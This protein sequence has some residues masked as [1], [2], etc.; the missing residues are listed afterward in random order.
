VPVRPAGGDQALN[1]GPFDLASSSA[2][3]R[4]TRRTAPL[5]WAGAVCLIVVVAAGGYLA[6]GV[7]VASGD[8][9]AAD[10]VIQKARTDSNQTISNRVTKAPTPPAFVTGAQDLAQTK[11]GVDRLNADFGR[12]DVV[13]GSDLSRLR[14]SSATLKAQAENILVV[15]ERDSLDQERRVVDDVASAFSAADG[16]LKICV[17][18]MHFIS[19][20]LDADMALTA[21]QQDLD[22]QNVRGAL[23]AFPTVDAKMQQAVSLSKGNDIPPQLRTLINSLSE[24]STDLKQFLQAEQAGNLSAMQALSAKIDADGNAIGNVDQKG[25]D[26]YEAQLYKPYQDSY[27]SALRRA[28][29]TVTS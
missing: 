14:R 18:Q 21:L 4:H 28:G 22:H 8:R 11:T 1:Q 7:A 15:P 3:D 17:N 27:Q 23:S 2:G 26:A 9:Q 19:S 20:M 25:L 10:V 13:V 12:A 5:V 6:A 16:A 24:V 29:F